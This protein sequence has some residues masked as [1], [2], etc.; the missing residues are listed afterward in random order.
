MS[1]TYK[2]HRSYFKTRSGKS[3]L[4]ESIRSILISLKDGQGNQTDLVFKFV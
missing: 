2:K 1:R 3:L 4:C